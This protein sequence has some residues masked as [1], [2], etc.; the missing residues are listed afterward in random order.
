MSSLST[1]VH[2]GLGLAA[3]ASVLSLAASAQV[4]G[5]EVGGAGGAI[6]TS[7]TGGAGAPPANPYTSTIN[8]ASIPPGSTS[9]V[10]VKIFGVTHTWAA[11]VQWV[12]E[13]PTG[14]KHNIFSRLGGSC[15]YAG[16]YVFVPTG[17]C[18]APFTACTGTLVAPGTY[19]QN[20][21]THVTGTGGINNTPMSSIVPA[22]GNWTLYAYDYAGGDVGTVGSWDLCFGIPTAGAPI[23]APAQTGPANGGTVSLPTTL[24]W[25]SISC[26]TTY[27]VELDGSVAPGLTG[28]SFLV[29]GAS[30]GIHNWRV[31]AANGS[32]AGPWSTMWSFDVPPPPPAATCT[33]NG[34]G[35]G[36]V[37][38]SGT[39][40]GGAFPATLPG[41]PYTNT[42]AVTVPAGATQI[43]KVD[44]DF[45]TEHTWVGDLQF[46]LTDPSGVSHNLVCLP[47]GNCDLNGAYSIYETAGLSWPTACP[48]STDVPNGGYDQFFGT[49]P[50]G[51]NNIFN[52]PLGS[53]PVVSGNWTLTIYDWAGG[54]SGTLGDWSLCFNAPTGPISYCTAGVT[55]NGCSATISAANNPS[56]SAANPCVI[57]VTNVEGAKSGLIF[58]SITGSS[59]SAWNASSFLCV[60]A[61][62]Q[63][64]GTQV[65]GGTA[66]LCDG[67]LTLDWNAYQAAFPTA[68]GQ[69]WSA[70][71]TVWAQ[72][73]FRDPPAGK[74]TNLSNG[75]EMTYV[76]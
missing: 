46:V 61:P 4:L 52:T 31:R 41:T 70:G 65:S 23:S 53:I 10:A 57:N 37:P 60:K 29:S 38:A 44:F 21:G 43:V 27:D 33:T 49:W 39:G 18:A 11:D 15:D 47:L 74:S 40:G 76:P 32:G 68:L 22:T 20:F 56:V 30:V 55:T 45:T 73:W 64:T 5:C 19:E 28:T 25:N 9:V 12:L 62:T 8:V 34:T 26:A 75:I 6:P 3:A 16:D 1:F 72:A 54:D 42:Y 7:G 67:T 35:A 51:T 63:R 50:T 2:R 24:T 59:T 69:P 48:A 66:G 14:T 13:D 36:P 58:Y 17:L 71:D